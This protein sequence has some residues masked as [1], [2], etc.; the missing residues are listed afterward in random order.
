M[1]DLH[2]SLKKLLRIFVIAAIGILI[3]IVMVA[4]LAVIINHLLQLN[5]IEMLLFISILGISL[6]LLIIFLRWLYTKGIFLKF[7]GWLTAMAL[8][9]LAYSTLLVLDN[10]RDRLLW[11]TLLT[12]P[13]LVFAVLIWNRAR[14][15]VAIPEGN[16]LTR[17]LVFVPGLLASGFGAFMVFNFDISSIVDIGEIVTLLLGGFGLITYSL[18]G[19]HNRDIQEAAKEIP[20]IDTGEDGK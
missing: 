16:L 10:A 1:R 18:F 13:L 3:A 14:H 5:G 15:G 7:L 9:V 4:I 11:G 8:I 17:I 12:Y 2:Q 20:F 19:K 6:T